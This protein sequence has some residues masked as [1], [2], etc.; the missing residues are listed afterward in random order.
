MSPIFT[1]IMVILAVM[2]VLDLIVGV[3]NDAINFLNSSLGSKVASIKVI[4]IVAAFGILAGVLTSSGMMEVARNGV[5]HPE[6]FTFKEVMFLFVGVMLADVVLLNTFNALG[7][8]TSTTVSLIFELLGS[9]VAVAIF[10]IYTDSSL[11]IANIED[12]I[13]T[14]KALGMIT[15]ILCSVVLA[16][17]SGSVLMYISRLIFTFRY[18]NAMK[19]YGALWCGVAITGIIYFA[20]FKGLKSSG[21]VTSEFTGY[22][23]SNI[24][25]ILLAVWAISSIVLFVLQKLNVSILKVTILS[26]TFALALA[27]AGND[28]VNFIGVPLAGFDSYTMVLESGNES[29]LMGGLTNSTPATI[30]LLLIAGLIMAVTLFFSRDAMKVSATELKLSSQNAEDE[31]FGSSPISRSL[32]R[33]AINANRNL[34]NSLPA[35][36]IDAVNRRFIPTDESE[37][38]GANYDKIRAVVNLTAAAIL[39]CLGTSLKLPLSTTYVVFMVAM[40]SSLADRAWGRDS[41]VYRISGVLIVISGWFLTA[42]IGFTLS[43]LIGL[44][45]AVGEGFALIALVIVCGYLLCRRFIATPSKNDEDVLP[46]I[47]NDETDKQVLY[48]YTD[49]ICRTMNDISGIYNRMLVALYTENRNALKEEVQHSQALYRKATEAKYGIVPTLTRLEQ[50]NIST[51]HFYV[52]VVDYI[53]EVTKALMHCTRPAYDHLN[54]NHRGFTGEQIKDLKQIND[55]VNHIFSVINEML[56]RRDFSQLDSIMDMRDAL[57]DTIAACIKSQIKRLKEADS[58]TRAGALY[59]NLLNETKTMVLQARNVIKAQAYFLNEI[60]VTNKDT[61][62]IEK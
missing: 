37:L 14:G 28:L 33:F 8:P 23:S 9:A 19:R 22:V 32:V 34:R 51:A 12:F 60:K 16:F 20:V 13:N 15:G 47:T 26:G 50:L 2:A 59:F 54:N 5:F 27:F 39:I 41:A 52:Q 7:L 35:S 53:C 31:R 4:L 36:V 3:S 61:E 48:T 30:W 58:S 56:S 55:Q 25:V 44:F 24:G 6:M 46:V 40:G 42:I 57:F 21:I 45:I 49:A 1:I 43:L 11:T 38:N 18:A 62:S 17:I 29:M 10:K